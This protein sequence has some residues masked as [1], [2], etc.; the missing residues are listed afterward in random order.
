MQILITIEIGLIVPPGMGA[1][2][3]LRF[4]QFDEDMFRKFHIP[5]LND[6]VKF[7][8]DIC[9]KLYLKIMK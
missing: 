2:L 8:G 6:V 4:I 9:W 7:V 5:V 1:T 3:R